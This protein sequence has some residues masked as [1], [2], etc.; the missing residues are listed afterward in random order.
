MT[1][2]KI[3]II[4]SGISGLASAYFLSQKYDIKIYEKHHYLGGH[5]NTQ[6]VDYDGKKIPVDTG[7]IVFNHQT[8]PNLKKF[9]ELLKVDYKKSNMSFAVKFNNGELEYAGTNLLSVFAQKKNLFDLQFLRM[10][11]DILFF[12]KKAEKILQEKFDASYSLKQ[13]LDDLKVKKYFRDFYLLPMSGAIWSCPLEKMLLY[14]AQSFVRFFKNHGLL[15][16]SDQPQWYTVEGGSVEYVKKIAANFSDKI[17]LNDFVL[18]VTKT[19][20]E[21]LLVKSEKSEEIFDKV[22]I[23]AHGDQA[24]EMLPQAN[25]EQISILSKFK[26]QKNLA[27][28]HKDSSIM[29]KAKKAW[30]SWVY[31]ANSNSKNP[32]KNISVSYWMNNLQGIDEKYPLFVTLNPISEIKPEKVIATFI[33]EHPIFDSEAVLAQEEIKKI[34]GVDG[35]YFC[36]AYQKYGFHEDGLVSGLKVAK[37]LGINLP[38][39]FL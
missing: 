31:A 5:S 18:T 1:K 22:V 2:E 37:Q 34:Q 19:E 7:F 11:R 3:A 6:I 27:V 14:P 17:S 29:P 24:L 16:T 20:N 36:G 13:F 33:Y 23:A 4:G 30:A 35:I 10:L 28:L 21:K 38:K 8:Y 26:Y 39:G 32:N 15:T 25:K 9:F 12:N